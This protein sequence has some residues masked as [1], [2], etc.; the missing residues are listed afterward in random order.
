MKRRTEKN[1]ARQPRINKLPDAVIN[2]IAAGEVVERPASI[3]KELMENSLDAGATSIEVHLKQGGTTEI[4]VIDNGIGMGVQDLLHCVLPHTTSK[5]T[6]IEDLDGIHSFGFRGEAL[7]SIASVSHFEVRS[8]PEWENKAQTLKTVFGEKTEELKPE[9]S[10]VG[11]RVSVTQL[12]GNTP[13]RQKFLRSPSTEF[14]HCQKIFKTLAL[15]APEVSFQLFHEDRRVTQFLRATPEQRFLNAFRPKWEP[16][17]VDENNDGMRMH[18]YLSP[19]HCIQNRGEIYLF[20][21]G[22]AVKNRSLLSAIRSAYLDTLGPHH[23]PSGLLHL[24]VEPDRLDVNVHPQKWEVRCLRQESIYGWIR[25]GLRKCFASQRSMRAAEARPS[26]VTTEDR[27]PS[28]APTSQ[29]RPYREAP[30]FVLESPSYQPALPVTPLPETRVTE[31]SQTLTS[32]NAS[33][34][35][36]LS[37]THSQPQLRYLGQVKSAY[38]VCEDENGVVFVDQH[39][40]HEKMEYERLKT[41][42]ENGPMEVQSLLVPQVIRIPADLLSVL[43]DN[44]ETL[45]KIGFEIE[46]FGEGD[47]AVKGLPVL[48]DA[49]EV[50]A[51]ILEV[52]RSFQRQEGESQSI[53]SRVVTPTLATVACHSVVRAGQKLSQEKALTLLD[54][55]DDLSEG[56]TCPHGRPVI[57]RLPFPAIEKYFERG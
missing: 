16:M 47:I 2:Q 51:V 36:Q 53:V 27:R 38:L 35:V 14:S 15:G 19:P 20:I 37:H 30:S 5:I 57:F 18:G 28:F 24:G 9:A 46:A 21:N 34:P 52:L 48:L 33:R 50:E 45:E 3:V 8:R 31:N 49:N 43:E 54:G 17:E 4:T 10:P 1:A 6:S 23:E 40:L 26:S 41:R 11:T 44:Q 29:T 55:L 13:A 12:F 32:Q 56:W 22:R 39:A 7:A 25:A 42:F